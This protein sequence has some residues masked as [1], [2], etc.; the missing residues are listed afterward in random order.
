ML[1]GSFLEARVESA[2]LGWTREWMGSNAQLLPK[3]AFQCALQ[4][5]PHYP[6]PILGSSAQG[7]L[8]RWSLPSY[9][10][11]R[12]EKKKSFTPAVQLPVFKTVVVEVIAVE[13]AGLVELSCLWSGNDLGIF[14]IM[15]LSG[16]PTYATRSRW[17]RLS[18]TEC[19]VMM[20]LWWKQ[21][22]KCK[23]GKQYRHL[24]MGR[25]LTFISDS[26]SFAIF[27]TNCQQRV[28]Y[29]GYVCSSEHPGLLYDIPTLLYPLILQP[30]Q[31]DIR[32]SL[33]SFVA[34]SWNVRHFLHL[35]L[36]VS[37]NQT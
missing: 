28:Y 33:W 14:G 6:A 30:N 26:I 29:K 23:Q 8:T 16:T 37:Q 24:F 12:K 7:L 11:H 19:V 1:G 4:A 21:C 18:V 13:S 15:L 35:L 5:L 31:L 22:K 34:F 17:W 2:S 9:N 36:N 3:F 25:C 10:I 32:D 27:V 20:I